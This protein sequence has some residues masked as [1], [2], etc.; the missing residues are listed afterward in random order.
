[1][2]KILIVE[3]QSEL[4]KLVRMTLEHEPNELHEACDG[5]AGLHMLT[6]IDPDILL[7]DVMVPGSIDGLQLCEL[8]KSNPKTRHKKVLI[9]S[10]RGQYADVKAWQSANADDYMVKPFSPRELINKVEALANSLAL[11]A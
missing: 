11:A 3:D 9:L 8:I 2:I 7:L 4:R 1:M 5:D 6:A 10:V